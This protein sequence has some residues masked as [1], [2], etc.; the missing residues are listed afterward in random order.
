MRD[1]RAAYIDRQ[2][3]IMSEIIFSSSRVSS[4]L[5]ADSSEGCLRL[6]ALRE[7]ISRREH[8][9]FEIIKMIVELTNVMSLDLSFVTYD[10]ESSSHR[11]NVIKFVKK[12]NSIDYY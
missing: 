11:L 5:N 7:K 10:H 3:E 6:T 8:C 1:S 4:P 9:R 2:V 12:L